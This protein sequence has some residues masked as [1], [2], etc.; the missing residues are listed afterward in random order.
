M[1]IKWGHKKWVL[2]KVIDKFNSL[3]VHLIDLG[4]PFASA[5][6]LSLYLLLSTF[7]KLAVVVRQRWGRLLDTS[8]KYHQA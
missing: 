7:W 6:R 3:E 1:H 2:N 5:F 4:G 8:M